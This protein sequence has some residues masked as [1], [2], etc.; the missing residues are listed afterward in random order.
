MEES[1]IY[2][3]HKFL[4]AMYEFTIKISKIILINFI[5]YVL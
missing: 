2:L 5:I 1:I 4:H 3:F